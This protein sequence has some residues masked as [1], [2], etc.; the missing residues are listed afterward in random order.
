[1]STR[2]E[3]HILQNFAPSNLNRD[4]T[5]APK[6]TMFGGARRG[7]ISSQAQKRAIR[8]HMQDGGLIPPSARAYRTARIAE[9]LQSELM[10]RGYEDAE[11]ERLADAAVASIGPAKKKLKLNE[12]KTQYLLFVGQEE[13]TQLANL[14]EQEIPPKQSAGVKVSDDLGKGLTDIL[15]QRA[16][17]TVDVAL[18]G[19]MLADLPDANTDAACQVAHAISTH[20]V[21]REFDYFTAV[22]DRKPEDTAGAGMIGT[23]E[24]N[25]S[26]Y[27][28]YSVIDLDQFH[29]NVGDESL[30]V[31]GTLAYLQ[32]VAEAIPSG[33]QNTFAAHNMPSVVLVTLRKNQVPR[34]LAN[35]FERPVSARNEGYVEESARR[36]ADHWDKLD[37]AYGKADAAW[38][39]DPN[40]V[41]PA[42]AAVKSV[43]SLQALRDAV[44]SVLKAK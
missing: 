39:L 43:S 18:F 1:M 11:A 2:I 36:L 12:R 6:D 42:T 24:F 3:F 10:D 41:F 31:Q 7:R 9:L 38:V 25:S 40:G 29:R 19:R 14:I 16:K 21:D 33:K 13:L 27:Y 37:S 17:G 5:G 34:N 8:L 22:D 20:R 28:R 44:E 15:R 32:A 30:T 35:A 4:D 26:C 23:I